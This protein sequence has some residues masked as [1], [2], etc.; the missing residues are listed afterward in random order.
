MAKLKDGLFEVRGRRQ[1][2]MGINYLP[3][4]FGHSGDFWKTTDYTDVV[5][6]FKIIRTIG[7]EAIR[8]P[9]PITVM[10]RAGQIDQDIVRAIDKVIGL[11]ADAGLLVVPNLFHTGGFW[12]TDWVTSETAF[13][14]PEVLKHEAEILRLIVGKY[15]DDERILAWDICNE[16]WWIFGTAWQ[17]DK[18]RFRKPLVEWVK[19]F[20]AE[21]RKI[22]A[23]QPFTIGVDHAGVCQEVG[24][25]IDAIGAVIDFTSTHFYSRY[26][27]GEFLID[28]TNSIR[29]TYYGPFNLVRAT[30]RGKDGGPFEFGN[31]T[32]FISE[33][34]QAD[35]MRVTFYSSLANGASCWFPWVFQDFA[36]SSW[37]DY[38]H[39]PHE[40]Y[41]GMFR[42]DGSEK[43]V[44]EEIRRFSRMIKTLEPEK[45]RR[46][47]PKAAILA[48]KDWYGD[49]AFCSRAAFNAFCL[50]KEAGIDT[51]HA[52]MSDDW[53]PYRIIFCLTTGL[54][55]DD[56][57]KIR[58]YVENGGVF[59]VSPTSS[60]LNIR[61]LQ[62][63]FGVTTEEAIY[64]TDSVA[65]KVDRNW[66][67]LKKGVRMEFSS[68][69]LD[70]K[71][72][73]SVSPAGCDVVMS[74]TLG[75][76]AMT[77]H[78][79]GK[80]YAV[81]LSFPLEYAMAV[82]PHAHQEIPAWQVYRAIAA[83]T[84]VARPVNAEHPYIETGVLEGRDSTIA[85]FINHERT[86]VTAPVKVVR[87]P[88]RVFELLSGKPVKTWQK[89]ALD[90][91][92][93]RV[94]RF[95]AR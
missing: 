55:I 42:A 83:L 40:I 59:V 73:Y 30:P 53:S 65:V 44:V 84:D 18:A 41:F 34:K 92:E 85:M 24:A 63:L 16:P 23:S 6:D 5:R 77:C 56:M 87:E 32:Q 11:A 15:R 60:Y 36:Q 48:S 91:S 8:L 51:D 86:A 9:L 76:P 43:P 45:H 17:K 29:D 7:I 28:E 67:G 4:R 62:E 26:I 13:S 94:W 79:A 74:D 33:K 14:S 70:G 69:K 52:K 27:I 75:R 37:K 61:Y 95:E 39:Q 22:G 46:V 90:P 49:L 72:L 20:T 10:P 21:M 3:A 25:E 31:S 57:D 38:R 82:I 58:K 93:V 80:G 81:L 88:R 2:V 50:A 71:F 35:H 89:L 1:Y 78:K 54:T 64:L 68:P 47:T 12:K 19:K 66:N